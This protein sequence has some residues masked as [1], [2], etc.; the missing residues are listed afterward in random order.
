MSAFEAV[1]SIINLQSALVVSDYLAGACNGQSVMLACW[2]RREPRPAGI[3][4]AHP[5]HDLFSLPA[6]HTLEREEQ[7]PERW[8]NLSSVKLR[9]EVLEQHVSRNQLYN[10]IVYLSTSVVCFSLS[11]WPDYRDFKVKLKGWQNS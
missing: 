5:R 9:G 6:K 10:Y 2:G 8:I 11:F 7:E 3:L 4:M 1:G